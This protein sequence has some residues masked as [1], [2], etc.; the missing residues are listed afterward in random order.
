MYIIAMIT[1]DFLTEFE[2][3]LLKS[4]NEAVKGNSTEHSSDVLSTVRRREQFVKSFMEAF[5]E[6]DD[7][8]G[9]QIQRGGHAASVLQKVQQEVENKV[10]TAL[11]HQ[12][13]LD[14][15]SFQRLVRELKNGIR[16]VFYEKYL[17]K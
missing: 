4:Y 3:S 13:S 8:L 7:V 17:S 11:F 2:V 5:R 9:T 6:Q 15:T 1:Q 14:K 10:R 16:S 12:D